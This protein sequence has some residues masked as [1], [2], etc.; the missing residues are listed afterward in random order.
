MTC[1]LALCL[2]MLGKGARFIRFILFT[3][4]FDI[5]RTTAIVLASAPVFEPE[6]KSKFPVP[7]NRGKR[8]K[9]LHFVALS[10][11]ATLPRVRWNGTVSDCF[12]YSVRFRPVGSSTKIRRQN[13][14]DSDNRQASVVSGPPV[15]T[16]VPLCS[17]HLSTKHLEL[18][19]FSSQAPIPI[20]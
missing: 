2:I 7:L 4:V 5:F 18:L 3:R 16:L 10:R 19:Q 1:D 8:C 6:V 11:F 14:I 9:S 13:T 17:N 15:H 20:A 12:A